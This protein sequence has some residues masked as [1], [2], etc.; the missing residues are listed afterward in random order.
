L[1]WVGLGWVGLG[2]VGAALSDLYLCGKI[3]VVKMSVLLVLCS[4]EIFRECEEGEGESKV[5][6]EGLEGWRGEKNNWDKERGKN[7]EKKTFITL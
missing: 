5:G 6:E 1:G 4:G 7:S 2:W 3:V